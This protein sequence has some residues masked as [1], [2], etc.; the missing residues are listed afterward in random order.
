M[1]S[2][3]HGTAVMQVQVVV[4]ESLA[5]VDQQAERDAERLLAGS[6]IQKKPSLACTW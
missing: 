6:P 2:S 3:V 5:L 1:A 4:V